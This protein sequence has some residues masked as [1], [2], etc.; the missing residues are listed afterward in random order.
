MPFTTVISS[1]DLI[2]PELTSTLRGAYRQ[3]VADVA[4]AELVALLHVHELEHVDH[5]QVVKLY[6]IQKKSYHCKQEH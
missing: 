1:T 2:E 3:C 6:T 5:A 4:L